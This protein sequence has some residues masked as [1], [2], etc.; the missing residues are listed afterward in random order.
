MQWTSILAIFGLIWVMCA[1]IMLPLGIRTHEELG[2]D[3]VPGQA[4]S[5][6]GNFRPKLV[7]V[8]ATIL[9]ALLSGL[10]VANYTFGWIEADDLDVLSRMAAGE[11]SPD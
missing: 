2:A 11:S 1:F 4:D 9:A 8:R 5:A 10:F 6:P 3:K 7:I